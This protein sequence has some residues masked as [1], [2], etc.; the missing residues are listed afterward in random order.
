MENCS[1]FNLPAFFPPSV[2][3]TCSFTDACVGGS[4]NQSPERRVCVGSCGLWRTKKKKKRQT[5]KRG[6]ELQN[7]GVGEKQAASTLWP[8]LGGDCDLMTRPACWPQQ[9]VHASKRQ[10]EKEK[11]EG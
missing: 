11:K 9:C 8:R 5:E 7:T 2:K 6:R 1:F 10:M 3:C 4:K